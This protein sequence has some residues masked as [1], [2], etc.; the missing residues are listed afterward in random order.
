MDTDK[1]NRELQIFRNHVKM[2]RENII[3]KLVRD[4][5]FWQS[6]REANPENTRAVKKLASL[7]PLITHIR[8]QTAS[9]LAKA[10]IRFKPSKVGS[11]ATVE[12]RVLMRFAENKKLLPET[13]ALIR[14][15]ALTNKMEVLDKYLKGR[16]EGKGSKVKRKK[17]GVIKKAKKKSAEQDSE[18]QGFCDVEYDADSGSEQRVSDD[19]SGAVGDVKLNPIEVKVEKK[20]TKRKIDRKDSKIQKNKKVNRS[21][22]LDDSGKC[23]QI[24]DSFFVTSSGQS[25]VATAPAVDQKV[26]ER[27][28]EF[29]WKRANKRKDIFG[30]RANSKDDSRWK[31]NPQAKGQVDSN[32]HPSWA[33]KQ[34]QKGLQPFAGKK[35]TFGSED[36][37][38]TKES[39]SPEDVNLHPS[40]AAKQKQ[41]GIKPFAG[42]RI[43]FNS[44]DDAPE[45]A[46]ANVHPSWAAKQKQREIKPFQGKK[47]VFESTDSTVSELPLLPSDIHPSWAAKQKEKGIKEFRGKKTTFDD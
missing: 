18:D 32:L 29:S 40:W 35:I 34:K 38:Q 17:K 39:A 28:D 47:I 5:K 33:A 2:A 10:V 42:K 7:E 11:T 13:K 9:E 41:K 19:A 3:H 27:E 12:E 44:T 26:M 36:R 1:L 37:S 21:E 46:P 45:P 20:H 4:I 25:Y 31:G 43:T 22:A 14:R 6:K 16:G 30:D 8:T 23:V 15:F 24:Q